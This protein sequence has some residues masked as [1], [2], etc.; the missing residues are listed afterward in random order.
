MHRF[1]KITIYLYRHHF[2]RYLIV[3]GTTFI[4]DFGL[5]FSLYSKL[6]I[7]IAIS[8]SVAYWIAVV[9][10]FILNRYWTFNTHEKESLKRHIIMY[11]ALLIVNYLFVVIFVSAL[12]H[13]INYIFAKALAVIIQM[14]WTYPVYKKIIF[15]SAP[16]SGAKQ[17]N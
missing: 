10:N 8:T 16:N 14:S 11:V 6:K 1:K 17:Q 2:I 12:S 15:V 4:I 5:L 13:H 3:G 9:Y 7:H